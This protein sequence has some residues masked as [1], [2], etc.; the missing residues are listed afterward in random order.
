[1]G[2]KNPEIN[3]YY[4][5]DVEEEATSYLYISKENN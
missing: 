2:F 5:N 4:D 3:K 1:M